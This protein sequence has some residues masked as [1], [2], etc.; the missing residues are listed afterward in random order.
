MNQ[1]ICAIEIASTAIR[2]VVAECEANSLQRILAFSE[3]EGPFL[4]NGKINEI[5]ALAKIL[6]EMKT[7]IER[8]L[9][10]GLIGAY[11]NISG[12]ELK[13]LN[14]TNQVNILH[15]D[16]RIRR[17]DIHALIKLNQE[18]ALKNAGPSSYALIHSLQLSYQL[19]NGDVVA[20]PEGKSSNLL[21][22]NSQH[23]LVQ[24]A[25]LSDYEYI[26]QRIGL[27]FDGAIFNGLASAWAVVS[28]EEWQEGVCHLDM[29]ASTIDLTCGFRNN[30]YYNALLNLGGNE[31]TRRL[32]VQMNIFTDYME[33]IKVENSAIQA[34]TI[35]KPQLALP[36]VGL[37]QKSFV[38]K[39]TFCMVI[40]SYC[41]ELV[42]LLQ[43]LRKKGPSPLGPVKKIVL[44]GGGANIGGLKQYLA[45]CLG[46][47]VRLAERLIAIPPAPDNMAEGL[48]SSKY[49]TVL[50][51]LYYVTEF[52]N[53]SSLENPEKYN[54]K[55]VSK[56]FFK[57][58]F[59]E[60]F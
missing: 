23:I 51:M 14:E 48:R 12:D 60:L 19:D 4:V 8:T 56:N 2:I 33:V 45:N 52:K 41:D 46:L 57:N 36:F 15:K 59:K 49:A 1:S 17:K 28:A 53:D 58:F 29:G 6:Q 42:Q 3:V 32:A 30:I 27:R 5:N 10:T 38:S 13:S 35:H 54:L 18:R 16:K 39:D 7:D 20:D 11:V 25:L 22:L 24:K 44:S 34:K 37:D 26:F 55:F 21:V 47:E 9:G 31:L 40:K 50:G 43:Q